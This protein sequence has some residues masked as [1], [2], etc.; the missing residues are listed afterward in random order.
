MSVPDSVD[1]VG[2]E[3]D[4]ATDKGDAFDERLGREQAVEWVA[5]VEGQIRLKLGVIKR[6]RK[7]V[8]NQIE[9]RFVD[10]LAIWQ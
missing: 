4:I 5:M 9:N 3:D 7:N 2:V 6:D 10:P 8:E 1:T